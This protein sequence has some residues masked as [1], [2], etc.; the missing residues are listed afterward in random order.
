MP[1]L[2]SIL[3]M[4]TGLVAA[5][6][7]GAE[8]ASAPVAIIV[9][10][11]NPVSDLSHSELRKIL[12][13]ERQ[14]WPQRKKITL[15][16]RE[17]GQVDRGSVLREICGMTDANFERHVLRATFRGTTL[18]APRTINSADGMRR[19]VFNVPGAL[20]YLRADQVDDTV[21]VLRIDG[22]LPGEPGY[23]LSAGPSQPKP[24]R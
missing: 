23:V 20:G 24:G 1:R 6:L 5:E 19:F 21:K 2:M 3:V 8:Q 11:S 17:A 7:V 9:H 22:R 15:V 4:L 10:R 14:S 18:S 16:M 13:L 12:L